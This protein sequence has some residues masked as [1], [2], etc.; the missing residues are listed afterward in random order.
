[1]LKEKEKMDGITDRSHTEREVDVKADMTKAKG[2]DTKD[3]KEKDTKGKAK[4]SATAVADPGTW[5]RIAFSSSRQVR[6]KEKGS[7]ST[8]GA[9]TAT[10]KD[11]WREIVE[12]EKEE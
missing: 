1:M 2:K 4:E 11:T 3:T 7:H 10:N 6:E 8:V 12:V 9:T 5:Q